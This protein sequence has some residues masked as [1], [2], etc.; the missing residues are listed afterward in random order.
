MVGAGVADLMILK[1]SRSAFAGF[2]R[3]EYTTLARDRAIACSP[4]RSPPP[5]T[6]RQTDCEFGSL[7]QLTRQTLLEVFAEHD[8]QSVQHTLYA[9]GEAVLDTSRRHLR[10]PAGDAE[11]ASPADRP[12]AASASTNRNEIFVAT[13]EPHGL[14]EATLTR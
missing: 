8:S 7:W 3:D 9:M 10:D 4:R 1:S 11:Q 12:H 14:I 13:E 2:P 6:T 5:G